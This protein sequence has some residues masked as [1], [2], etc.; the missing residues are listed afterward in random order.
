LRR[1][2][3]RCDGGST[4]RIQA[5]ASSRFD[6]AHRFLTGVSKNAVDISTGH[7]TST[8]RAQ[9]FPFWNFFYLEFISGNLFARFIELP[10]FFSPSAD[11]YQ[12][13]RRDNFLFVWMLNG[14][15]IAVLICG[16]EGH[17]WD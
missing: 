10:C 9:L 3:I 12:I 15:L 13:H 8:T 7:P 17:G 16:G 2:S 5:V 4:P 1:N 6:L 11:A 14:K